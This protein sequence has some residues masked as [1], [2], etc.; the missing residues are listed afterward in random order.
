MWRIGW[1]S[2]FKTKAQNW[3]RN[4]DVLLFYVKNT[5]ALAPGMTF[6]VEPG[7][8]LPGR[9]GVRLE[10]LVIVREDGVENLTRSP[11]VPVLA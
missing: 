2:G 4:H 9:F 7:I 8:Y 1:V 6:T 3:I 5:Q 10:D 11:K